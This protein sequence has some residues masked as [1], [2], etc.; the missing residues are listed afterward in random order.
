MLTPDAAD[1]GSDPDNPYLRNPPTDFEVL[2]TLSAERAREQAERLREA[3]Y[4]HDHR[5]YVENDP[6]IGDRTY[7]ALFSRLVDL[8]EAFDL[9]TEDSP[10]QR[11]GGEPIDELDSRDHVAPMLSIDSS[12]DPEAV[13][14]FDERV[15]E[16]VGDVSYLCEP[17]FDGLSIEIVYEGGSY[18]RA[19]TRGD[20]ETGDD[21]TSTVRTIGSVPGRLRGAPEA[22]P[23]FLAVRGEIYIPRP[24]F[25]EMNRKRVKR[26]A[27]PFANP[28]NAAAGTLRQLDPSIAAGRPLACFFFEVL[29]SGASEGREEHRSDRVLAS[30]ASESTAR[31]VDSMGRGEDEPTP[32]AP[33]TNEDDAGL[34]ESLADYS[35]ES[36]SRE[37]GE[38]GQDTGSQR[39]RPNP[40]ADEEETGS[41]GPANGTEFDTHAERREALP[42]WGLRTDRETDLR[43]GIEEAIAYRDDL[44]E[45]REELDYEIDGVVVKVND[46]GKCEELGATSRAP[47][48]AYAYKF[49]A[50]TEITTIAEIA[51]QVG[52]TG[53]LT[54]VALL[55]PVEVG[56]VTVSRASL[57]NPEEISRLGVGIGDRVRIERAGDVIPQVV[58]VIENRSEADFE[59]PE[60][61]PVCASPVEH[62]G[63]LA[64]CS[65]GLACPAQLQGAIEHYASRTGLDI[66]GL[67]EER[68]DQL[69]DTGLID[70]LADLYALDAAALTDLEGWG[71]QSAS[72]LL[73]ELDAAKDPSLDDF[74]A[75]LGVPEVGPTTATALA[76][77]FGS[78]DAVIA[79]ES[80][81]LQEVPDIG[82]RVA[83]EIREFFD[84]E[85]NREAIA[86]LREQGVE[87]VADTP[88][89]ETPDPLEGLTFV[90]TG[91]LEDRTREEAE[92]L[93]ER[94]GASSAG[95][96]SGNTDFLVIGES[97]GA[98]KREAADE[99]SVPELDE[100]DLGALLAERGIDA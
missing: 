45:R 83:E 42:E 40:R 91:A 36:G 74:L 52:R 71:E 17:K 77:E 12:G 87:P 7:D 80:E 84:S 69:I 46:H 41:D 89:A 76:R 82:P 27:E 35:E 3:I 37:D 19:V 16:A 81:A 47:R 86:A 100:E 49:P 11:V 26:G 38:R 8:E 73:A 22:V 18:V 65:G 43:S 31:S 75:A 1:G 33:P 51:V 67:G 28:R 57:H 99:H 66:E 54:P 98:R 85:R 96:V 24:A 13:R 14:A 53:R 23:D 34:Q 21:V 59:F 94:Y 4:A 63:P 48:W 97:P 72:N 20:G 55:D 68:I 64:Y 5:Y 9:V 61:C 88:A 6:V 50:R 79:A 39:E 78:L 10:T 32:S 95:S 60:Q 56:G 93:V 15:R 62:A 44:L 2:D 92:D 29:A 30:E 25:Q 70:S 90:F 58:E